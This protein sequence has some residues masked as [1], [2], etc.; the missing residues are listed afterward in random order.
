MS[1]EET[2]YTGT[3]QNV[4]HTLGRIDGK[5]DS[6]DARVRSLE[7]R[8]A[9]R[10]AREVLEMESIVLMKEKVLQHDE[11]IGTFQSDKFVKEALKKY[12]WVFV[13]IVTPILINLANTIHSW[14]NQP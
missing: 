6:F 14:Q 11:V 13:A 2:S 9:G 1:A 4:Y 8:E 3:L 12:W 7:E 10:S 5:L